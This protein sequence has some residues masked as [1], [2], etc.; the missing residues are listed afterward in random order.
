MT[1]DEAGRLRAA[2]KAKGNPPCPHERIVESLTTTDGSPLEQLVCRECGGYV[3]G[4]LL[5]ETPKKK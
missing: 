5:H 4:P 2:W 3:S 1:S